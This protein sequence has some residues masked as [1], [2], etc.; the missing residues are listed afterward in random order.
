MG[1]LIGLSR[2]L[3]RF[4]ALVIL[5]ASAVAFIEPASFAWVKGDVQ[6]LVSGIIMLGMGMTLGREDYRILAQ[7]P[8][9]VFIGAAAQ[10]TVM[11]LLAIG[12]AKLFDLSPGLTLGLV[13]VGACPGGVSSNIMGFLAKGDVAFSVGM[14]TVSTVPA[15]AVKPLWMTCLAGQTVDMDGCGMFRFSAVATVFLPDGVKNTVATSSP[16]QH[17]TTA[18]KISGGIFAKCKN[19]PLFPRKRESGNLTLRQFV[20]D[21]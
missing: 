5:L 21:G 6:A 17:L 2:N 4:T 14:T 19:I 15:P 20:G 9:D 10:Y 12:I 8:L 1:F 13:L 18:E 11:P 7:R 3:T 16:A